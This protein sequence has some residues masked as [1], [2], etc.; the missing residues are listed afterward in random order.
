MYPSKTGHH[1]T[2]L[3]CSTGVQ[4]AVLQTRTCY[5]CHSGLVPVQSR[6]PLGSCRLGA[7]NSLLATGAR[8]LR[9]LRWSKP[10]PTWF[11][12]PHAWEIRSALIPLVQAQPA[13]VSGVRP[14]RSHCDPAAVD[15]T[16]PRLPWPP[17]SRRRPSL[18][19][20]GLRAAP[21]RPLPPCPCARRAERV[22]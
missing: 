4:T 20:P 5:S 14:G 6:V 18:A 3:L 21:P 9:Q 2:P 1:Q 15:R 17:R 8:P 7:M 13:A 11:S 22:T 12:V 16:W 19:L 10:S